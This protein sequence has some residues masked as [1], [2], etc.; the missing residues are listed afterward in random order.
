MTSVKLYNFDSQFIIL[1]KDS[2]SHLDFASQGSEIMPQRAFE[3][4]YVVVNMSEQANYCNTVDDVKAIFKANGTSCLLLNFDFIRTQ[5]SII[6]SEIIFVNYQDIAVTWAEIQRA[7][8]N[9]HQF[10]FFNSA[11]KMKEESINRS[12]Y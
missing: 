12:I 5:V 2:R 7:C 4:L 3:S 1:H 6:A 11:K 8:A 9:Q 10:T